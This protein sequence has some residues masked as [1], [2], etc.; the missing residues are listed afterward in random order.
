VREEKGRKEYE[1][2]FGQN[3]TSEK[4]KT[5]KREN[6]VLDQRKNVKISKRKSL[7]VLEG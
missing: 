6:L 7:R 2:W 5:N 1:I 3:I 4:K